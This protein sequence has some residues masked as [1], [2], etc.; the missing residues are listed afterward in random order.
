MIRTLYV[1]QQ[2]QIQAGW[3]ADTGAIGG[4]GYRKVTG[5]LPIQSASCDV[6]KPVEAVTSFGRLGALAL[7]QTNVTSCKASV[8][9]YLTSGAPV[10]TAG[11]TSGFNAGLWQMLQGDAVSGNYTV[12]SVSPNGFTMS[13]ILTSIGADLAAGGFGMV[14]MSFNGVGQPFFSSPSVNSVSE[15]ALMPQAIV[16]VTMVSVGGSI[17]SGCQTS[18]KFSMDMPTDVLACLGDQPDFANGTGIGLNTLIATK[19]PYKSSISVEGYEIDLSTT[20]SDIPPANAPYKLGSLNITLPNG[21]IS[22]K[23]FTNAVGTANATFSYTME[24]TS[25]TI[26]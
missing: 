19:P 8:K 14:D 23:T 17:L 5:Y 21:I 7:A 22:S 18:F 6:T 1:G 16:P 24:D 13:G 12:L 11:L 10:S 15:Q 20:S 3:V 2:V 25:A 26:T 9:A 4:L